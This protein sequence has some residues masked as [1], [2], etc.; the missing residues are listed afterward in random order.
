MM[1]PI[2]IVSAFGCLTFLF[3]C[4]LKSAEP[5]RKK[6]L[7]IGYQS[8]NATDST[9]IA[10]FEKKYNCDVTLKYI[11]AEDYLEL[12]AKKPYDTGIDVILISSDSIRK[13]LY[14]RNAL[15]PLRTLDGFND[16]ERQFQNKHKLW[17]PLYHDPLVVTRPADSLQDCRAINFDTWHAKDS[18][19]PHVYKKTQLS[20]YRYA[21]EGSKLKDVLLGGKNRRF[22]NET[23]W[24]LSQLADIQTS[25]DTT[26][27]K[28]LHSC[29]YVVNQ[30]KH[31]LT[32]MTSLSISKYARNR[33]TAIL[34][35][36]WFSSHNKQISSGR[37][38][39]SCVRNP[40]NNYII[41][42]LMLI[43]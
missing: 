27:I 42:N 37:N 18:M 29:K 17:Y 30:Q 26:Y 8:L 2:H 24:Q 40:Q 20:K 7:V 43:Y 28:R 33:G 16:L 32:L 39:L 31:S 19:K 5:V 21:I 10:G 14:E 41:R 38:Q 34:L 23:L 22:S 13:Q 9:V 11:T 4:V 12:A 35:I 25:T 36:N 15:Y 1:R 6:E 3:S